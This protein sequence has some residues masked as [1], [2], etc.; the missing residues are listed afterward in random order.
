MERR[1]GSRVCTERQ[2]HHARDE[3]TLERL[4]ARGLGVDELRGGNHTFAGNEDFLRRT[5][6]EVVEERVRALDGAIALL[7]ALADMQQRS[8]QLQC[9]H[10]HQFFA[11][12]ER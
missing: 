7:I 9:R 8:V 12:R 1:A 4:Q 2:F 11:I 3:R 5:S 6:E 10:C